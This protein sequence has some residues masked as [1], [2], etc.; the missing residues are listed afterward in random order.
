MHDFSAIFLSLEDMTFQHVVHS[1]WNESAPLRKDIK[2]MNIAVL[3]PQKVC[4]LI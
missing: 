3:L 4:P 2:K 1:V